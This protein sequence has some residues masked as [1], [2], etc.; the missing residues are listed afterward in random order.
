MATITPVGHLAELELRPKGLG[1]QHAVK[2]GL[3]ELWQV[4]NGLNSHAALEQGPMEQVWNIGYA[5]YDHDFN[6][7]DI[8][9]AWNK[10]RDTAVADRYRKGI[11][12]RRAK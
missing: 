10:G 7:E 12:E 5:S 9:H 8:L 11:A 3:T 1:K 4:L 2:A 6:R